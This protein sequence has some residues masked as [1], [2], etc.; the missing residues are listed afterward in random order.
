[1]KYK[2]TTDV[3][4]QLL[5]TGRR[6]SIQDLK[7]RHQNKKPEYAELLQKGLDMYD[8][9]VSQEELRSYIDPEKEMSIQEWRD[10]VGNRG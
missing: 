7:Y 8:K 2:T 4:L 5:K 3:M 10:E 9:H 1:M 6:K